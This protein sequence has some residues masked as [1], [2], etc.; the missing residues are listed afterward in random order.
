MK[1]KDYPVTTELSAEDAL[2]IESEDEGTKQTSVETV[3]GHVREEIGLVENTDKI[4]EH[5]TTYRG[6]KN[7]G[8]SFTNAQKEAISSGTFD[9]M[10]IGD[11]WLYDDV[12]WRIVDINYP[13][14]YKGN[15]I[16]VMPDTTI[17]KCAMNSSGQYNVDGWINGGYLNSI[18]RTSGLTLATSK[19]KALFGNDHLIKYGWYLTNTIWTANLYLQTPIASG[20]I[21]NDSLCVELPSV[22]H[23]Y[24]CSCLGSSQN[25]WDQ[26]GVLVNDAGCPQFK[27]FE[28]VPKLRPS[29]M[30]FWLRDGGPSSS[31]SKKP[32]Y[33]I[34]GDAVSYSQYSEQRGLRPFVLV[35][36]SE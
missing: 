8:S 25:A 6:G 34:G 33:L 31:T 36:G 11:Y 29:D 12:K 30:T 27:L 28:K 24:G 20:S 13:I 35:K 26:G 4:Y 19:L 21:W 14:Y 18:P 32:N 5:A 15:H 22:V 17:G 3:T 1:I 16:V 7:L 23:I 9:D 2:V 10:Y